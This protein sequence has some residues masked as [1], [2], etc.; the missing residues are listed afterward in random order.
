MKVQ[1]TPFE[2]ITCIEYTCSMFSHFHLNCNL[3]RYY[4]FTRVRNR[5]FPILN[6]FP[7]I[8]CGSWTARKHNHTISCCIGRFFSHLAFKKYQNRLHKEHAWFYQLIFRFKWTTP[9][10]AISRILQR[11]ICGFY[12]SWKYHSCLTLF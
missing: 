6:L 10:N 2:N 1:L 11:F 9:L 8:V 4:L 12:L 5:K 3:V 7:L